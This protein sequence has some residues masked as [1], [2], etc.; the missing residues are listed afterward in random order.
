[1]SETP[2]TDGA[3]RDRWSR[4]D[5]FAATPAAVLAAVSGDVG[6]SALVPHLTMLAPIEPIDNPLE[7]YP[8]RDWE[9]VYRDLYNPD[10][11]YHYLCA[12]NDTH[13]CLLKASVKNGIAVYADPSFGYKYA[14]DTYGNQASA[15]WDPR[16]C[17]SGLAYIRRAYS[18]R[19]LKGCYVRQGFKQWIDDGFPREADGQ[20]PLRYREG[21][22]KEDFVKATHEEAADLVARGYLD[23]ART[24]SGDDGAALLEAQGYYE[25][26]MIETMHG[27]GVQALKFRGG[28]PYNA[29]F[30][31]GGFYR[32]CNMMSL[33]DVAVRGVDP[34][35]SFGGRHWDSY[36]W[37]TDLPPGH[38]MVTGQQTLDFDLSTAENARLITLWGMNWIA[39]KMPDAHWLTEARLHGAKVVTIAPEYQSSSCKADRAIVIRAGSDGA[40][41]LGLAHVIVRDG[42]YDEEFVKTQTDLP[43]LIRSDTKKL[44][45][46]SDVIADYENAE[47]STVRVV[48]PGTKLPPAAE[49]SIQY[50]PTD[51][52]EEWG[53][54]MV[55]DRATR[56]PAVV[57]HD[58]TGDNFP[59]DV[60]A[61]LE[62]TFEV[63]LVDGSTV[64]VRPFFDAVKQHLE[65]SCTP[66]QI[67]AVTW[68][69]VDA[70]EEL[71]ADIAANP[72]KTLFVEGMGP[73][74]FFNNDNKDRTIIL[75]AALTNN[76]GHYGGTVG[77]YAGN[78]RL[79]TFS[80]IAQW[81]YEDPFDITLDP[82]EPA[83]QNKRIKSES[84][85]YYN[86]GDRPLKIGNKMFTGKTHMPTP[87]KTMQFAN[88]NSLLGNAKGAHDVMVNT[89]P[90]IEMI[91]HNDWYW[92]ASCEYADVVFG[93]DSWP[94]RQLPDVYGSVTNPFLQAWP[95]TPMKR[96][97]DTIDDMEVNALIA[98]ALGERLEDPRF[99][100]YWHFVTEKDP[101]VYIQRVFDQ[102]NATRGYRFDELHE[103]CKQ[104]TPF[105]MMM[106]TTPKIV[107]WE[108]TN[109]S[110]PWY[111]KTGRLE[112][113]RDEDEFIEYG[114]N[115]PLHRE[116][117]DGTV[118]EPGVLMA[119][120]HPL[121][122]PA[123]P[124]EYGLRTDD[125]STEVRQVRHVVRTPDEIASSEHP[126]R[127]QGFS[128]VLI[129]PKFRH[130]C[131]TMGASVDS[132]V[133]IFGPFGDFYRHDVRKPWV[134]EG[135]V[136]LH[137]DDAAEL[138]VADGDYVW[139]D[140]DPSDRPFKG[141]QDRP[142]D[143]HVFRWMTRV[144]V[145]PS[146][147]RKVARAWFH[148]H[149]ATHGSVEGHEARADGLARNPR[150]DYQAGYRY[151]SH[152]SA[153]RA[154]LRPTLMTDS[155]TRKNGAGQMIG[156]GFE[157]DVYCADG[158][159]KESF[160][161]FTKAEDGGES[162]EGLWY[163]AAQG[164]R[165]GTV[166][167]G[168]Q[169]YLSGAFIV[170][171]PPPA[172]T[173]DPI[174]D[175]EATD[176]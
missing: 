88:S 132:E 136:D 6:V 162:G 116:P 94:E 118:Y 101:G 157:L 172:P 137:P 95:S 49:Q 128:H 26:E 163:P 173:P 144:R 42:L 112:F 153:T 176:G 41:A 166:N 69:P 18:D 142:D 129:T 92:T 67:S 46:A 158:A 140:A 12:P 23:V 71:A 32:M 75:V 83:K 139:I 93:V 61:A 164:Y 161:K 44:L 8:N 36:S 120:P 45:L 79:P 77:S 174:D 115:M 22:G 124:E 154:W 85:H 9:Q 64:E 74:H 65:D 15:R 59:A 10:S 113:Y 2:R 33:V 37:H 25:P 52:R 160:V 155:L 24:Y 122:D 150:T 98:A 105:Y 72:T 17:V 167:E 20:P 171:S 96:I 99:A 29:P 35:E 3:S 100:E 114:E 110:V 31:I 168:M 11:T 56:Q 87:T 19:R 38:P 55:W 54:Q 108:Q 66:E 73:N 58:H 27:A 13:G 82:D 131:H 1:M 119:E 148:F 121:I 16:A 103:S 51:L 141:W 4:R 86:Y 80:G 107:G 43:L 34:E 111:T 147:V 143:Y 126:L 152:Q 130:A 109:E 14:T 47:L 76:V 170:P 97:F 90:K 135:F 63:T 39:T 40:L 62:G 146:V 81:L 151:G 149:V 30:R 21:R 117:V 138:G 78:Y 5:V 28:M 159:P 53:D 169:R 133:L 134:S 104:G 60:D 91:V 70:I 48:E 102:G 7:A 106:R 156:K 50:A 125:L 165:P 57:T 84:A 123:Q 145:N 68:V 89:L 175:G 127:A